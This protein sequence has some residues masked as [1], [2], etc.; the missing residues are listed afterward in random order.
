MKRLRRTPT[1]Q[2]V[3]VPPE[4]PQ[5]TR[6]S[7]EDMEIGQLEV[8]REVGKVQGVSL[9][10]DKREL[11]RLARNSVECY[12]RDKQVEAS[13][14]LIDE[15]GAFTES[16][17]AQIIET[18]APDRFAAKAG[19]LRLRPG[20]AIDLCENKPYGSHEGECWDLSKNSDVKELF[21]MIAFERP[22]IVTGS[23][24]TAFSQYQNVSWYPKWEKL[25]ATKL[26]H[27][28]MDVYEEQIRG[29]RHFLHEHPLEASSCLDPRVMSLQKRKG[30]FT[31]SSPV[32]CFPSEGRNEGRFEK[33]Q[34]VVCKPT[35]WMTNS[36]A[37]AQALDKRCSNSNEPPG[38]LAKMATTYAAELVNTVL[39][40]LRQ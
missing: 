27:V 35:K 4:V 6:N 12:F 19:D 1:E 21:E 15:V 25:Q 23:P 16:G 28:A 17:G 11:Q 14:A 30:V 26:L 24:C 31:A 38:G 18:V 29:G 5:D 33:C 36:K 20:F 39:R 22:M 37:L 32:C 9:D 10:K 40:G 7:I 2:R 34:Q 3:V 8:K 13:D